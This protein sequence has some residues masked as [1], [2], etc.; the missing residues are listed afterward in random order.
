MK[1][2]LSRHGP[3]RYRAPKKISNKDFPN[4]AEHY[5]QVGIR[6]GEDVPL[7]TVQLAR[8]SAVIVSSDVPRS[9][10]SALLLRNVSHPTIDPVFREAEIP[11]RMPLPQNISLRPW[12][13]I[14]I[15]RM[16]WMCGW[17]GGAT[18]IRSTWIRAGRA[19]IRLEQLADRHGTVML[20]GHQLFSCFVAARLRTS[21]WH[22][23]ILPNLSHWAASVYEKED[24]EERYRRSPN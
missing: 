3:S 12:A 10:E 1:I 9:I 17:T 23:P 15:R 22:G 16:F 6:G 11:L 19:G 24:D 7:S 14:V 13:W 5:H 8:S 2:I 18:S 21:G 4:E 20:V